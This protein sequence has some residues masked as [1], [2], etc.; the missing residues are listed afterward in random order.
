MNEDYPEYEP[1]NILKPVDK[2]IWIVDGPVIYWMRFPFPTRMTVIKLK[3]NDLFLHSP[4]PFNIN[5]KNELDK[6]GNIK[7]LVSP[8]KIHNVF[9]KEWAVYYPEA[10]KWASPGIRKKAL[11]FK[12]DKDLMDKPDDFWTDDIDQLIFRGSFAMEEVVFFHKDSRVLI[13]ADLIENYEKNLLNKKYRTMSKIGGIL[14]PDG[15]A[16]IDWRF[17][18]IFGKHK[19]R[20]AI[21]KMIAW[22]PEKIII[23][24]GK[25]FERNGT[26]ELK[27]AFSWL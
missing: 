17:S 25:W 8:N 24:H 16:P 23:A 4:T 6:I 12:F 14:A 5:L 7:H 15:K 21:K 20:E 26:E 18:F 2:N 9:I 27:R 1:I 3:N 19:A 13:L 10:I 22:Q 11:D